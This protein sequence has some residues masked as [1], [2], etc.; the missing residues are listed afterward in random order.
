MKD[1]FGIT[2]FVGARCKTSTDKEVY[3]I[4]IERG[5]KVRVRYPGGN[6]KKVYAHNLIRF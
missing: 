5:E 2:L 4:S 3:V 1:R 6:I